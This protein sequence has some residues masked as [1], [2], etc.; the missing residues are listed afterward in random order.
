M[1]T[2]ALHQAGSGHCPGWARLALNIRC[3]FL[4][5]ISLDI[6]DDIDD[7]DGEVDGDN[8]DGEDDQLG[9]SGFEYQMLFPTGV[10]SITMDILDIFP[11]RNCILDA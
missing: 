7:E 10:Q 11:K 9:Q 1:L 2:F 3:C 4:P 8:D 6:L 5:S